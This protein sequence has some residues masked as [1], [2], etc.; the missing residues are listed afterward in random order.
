MKNIKR[1]I[2]LSILIIVSQNVYAHEPFLE[3]PAVAAYSHNSKKHTSRSGNYEG[4]NSWKPYFTHISNVQNDDDRTF[5]QAT[6]G[7]G[8]IYFSHVKGDTSLNPSPAQ[9]ITTGT[10]TKKVGGFSYNR[11]PIY[12]LMIG[13]RIADWIKA[14]LALQNQNNIHFQS[15]FAP[16]LVPSDQ[17]RSSAAS[18]PESQFR[19]NI[20]L[21]AV[22]LKVMFDLPW[23]MV[24]KSWM[25][26]LY[27]NAGVGPCWQSW[28]DIRQYIQYT[29]NNLET[30]FVN[31]LHQKYGASALWQLDAGFRA[32]SAGLDS[33]ISFVLGCKFNSW[34]KIPNIG[35]ADQQGAWGFSF[36][37]PYSARML[38]SFAPYIGVQWNF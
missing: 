3:A 38:Y 27:F 5:V 19:A 18:L 22:Y 6:A 24:L 1:F 7:I 9:S 31:T 36:R 4:V 11:T 16:T 30:T 34:G 28:T 32:K 10:N 2:F 14:A 37:K 8:F 33:T 17:T 12:D 21:N 23:I 35:A 25:Y 20:A 15:R 26:G 13:Y 29:A